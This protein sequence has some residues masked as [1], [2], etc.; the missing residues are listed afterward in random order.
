MSS[1]DRATSRASVAALLIVLVAVATRIVSWWNP[2]AHV[3]DQF[4][5]LGGQE[6]LRGHWPYIDIWDRKPLGLFLIYAGIAAIG[7]SSVLVLNLVATSFAAATAM[8]VRQI[9]MRIAGPGAAL[10]AALTYLIVLPLYGGQNGQS[11]VFYNLFIAGAFLVLLR[12]AE[13]QEPPLAA[14][15]G[16]MLLCGLAMIVKPT[17]FVEGGMIGL[18]YLWLLWRRGTA[19]VPFALTAATMIAVALL[20]TLLCFLPYWLNGKA[21]ADA[22][23]YANYVSIFERRNFQAI[24]RLAGAALLMLYLFPLF[25]MAAIGG[26]KRWRDH[27]SQASTRLVIAWMAAA[28]FGYFSVPSFFDHYALPLLPPLCVLAAAFFNGASGRLWFAAYAVFC[29]I[30]GSILDASSNRHEAEAYARSRTTV[31]AS[32]QGGCVYVFDGPSR[33]YVDFPQCRPT[34]YL[35]PDHISLI[36]E[37]GAVGTD[38]LVELRRILDAKPAVIVTRTA[39]PGRQLKSVEALLNDR[40]SQ[41][42]RPVLHLPPDQ[43]ASLDNLTIWQ[44]SDLSG[45][46]VN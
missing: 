12:S 25:I 40:L 7:G 37:A 6:L 21:A 28:I 32:M 42:Y 36:T 22:Y 19:A 35:F 29:L 46:P 1:V 5:L 44:R 31:A 13:R 16:S 23:I 27:R 33:L 38:T 9:A 24:A 3:D 15:M 34:K 18:G 20:P 4:Y 11:P 39:Q 17:S 10:M 2:I 41:G 14:A 26:W 8:V 43:N 45:P 30:Q